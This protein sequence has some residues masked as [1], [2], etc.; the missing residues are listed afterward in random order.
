MSWDP[1]QSV[2]PGPGRWGPVSRRRAS[3][4]KGFW[5]TGISGRVWNKAGEQSLLPEREG[6][7][8]AEGWGSREPLWCRA[9]EGEPTAIEHCVG[10]GKSLSL[11]RS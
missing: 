4:W 8:E 11:S 6:L 1:G 3:I 9:Q 2:P 7:L 5:R 10:H